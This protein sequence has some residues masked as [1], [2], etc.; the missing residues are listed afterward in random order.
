MDT[1]ATGLGVGDG[2][3]VGVISGFTA[4][5]ASQIAYKVTLD[6]GVN[7]AGNGVTPELLVDQPA[8]VNPLFSI[9]RLLSEVV[10]LPMF[11]GSVIATLEFSTTLNAVGGLPEFAPLRSKAIVQKVGIGA[12]VLELVT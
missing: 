6:V 11:P 12:I 3:G 7:S 9:G 1:S 10:V 2:V 8:K 5:I 4:G